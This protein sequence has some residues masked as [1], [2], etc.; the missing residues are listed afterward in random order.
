MQPVACAAVARLTFLV[1][2][3][4]PEALKLTEEIADLKSQIKLLD[5]VCGAPSFS[6]SSYLAAESDN[7]VS[8]IL[9]TSLYGRAGMQ[10]SDFVK[11][12]KVQRRMINTEKSLAA[13]SK[14]RARLSLLEQ[15]F[16][17]IVYDCGESVF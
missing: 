16:R 10:V 6:R 5:P 13:L 14:K 11:V 17:S 8:Q 12:S 9:F 7:D 4:S 3:Q 15:I 2:P 1:V